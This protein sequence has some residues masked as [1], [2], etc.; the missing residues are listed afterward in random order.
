MNR[1]LNIAGALLLI[2]LLVSYMVTYTVRFNEAVIVT[3]FGSTGDGSVKNAPQPSAETVRTGGESGLHFKWPWPIQQVAARYDTRVQVTEGALEQAN[4]RDKQSVIVRVYLTWRI[5]DPL[6]FYKQVGTTAE[7]E[8][9]LRTRIRDSQSLIGDYTF[10]QL[11]N[12]NESQLRLEELGDRMKERI[13][14]RVDELSY[15]IRVEEVGVKSIT[16]P[17]PVTQSVFARMRQ[18]RTTLADVASNEGQADRQALESEANNQRT[19]ILSF[20][21]QQAARIRNQGDQ[22]AAE[23]Y[24]QFAEDQELASFL[25]EMEMLRRVNQNR[26]RFFIDAQKFYPFTRIAEFL[27]DN[28][29]TDDSAAETARNAAAAAEDALQR[30]TQMNSGDDE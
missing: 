1:Y 26:V 7:A 23:Q 21:N 27:N 6:Q 24:T 3:T 22:R 16:L 2:I 20:A 14:A 30:F 17:G 29:S 4:T 11:A 25:A 28:Q 5:E 15:G 19:I 9:A 8:Q 10:D 18:E 12:T 13:Q